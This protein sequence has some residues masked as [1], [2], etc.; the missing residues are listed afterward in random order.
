MSESSI[1]LGL[2]EGFDKPFVKIQELK[3]NTLYT[4]DDW[5]SYRIEET[6]RMV[7]VCV[8]E[9]VRI[10]MP[11]RIVR[12]IMAEKEDWFHGKTAIM[13]TGQATSVNGQYEYP[14]FVFPKN[15]TK[16]IR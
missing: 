4:I 10:Y 6:G 8:L 7:V 14:V 9:D 12:D 15:D 3:L 2:A 16:A 5:Y 11:P 1:F 13:Y